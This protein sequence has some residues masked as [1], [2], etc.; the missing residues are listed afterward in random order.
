MWGVNMVGEVKS[1]Q[2]VYSLSYLHVFLC[3]TSVLLTYLE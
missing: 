2:S 3:P 1:Q